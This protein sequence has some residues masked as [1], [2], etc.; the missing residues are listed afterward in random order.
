MRGYKDGKIFD[1]KIY[2][3]KEYNNFNKE[4]LSFDDQ[5]TV[6]KI[7]DGYIIT[8]M[9]KGAKHTK[10]STLIKTGT[11]KD[12]TEGRLY[13]GS[14]DGKK[15]RLF[16]SKT[17]H[18]IFVSLTYEES[19]GDYAEDTFGINKKDLLDE[20]FIDVSSDRVYGRYDPEEFLSHVQ[21]GFLSISNI[22][23]GVRRVKKF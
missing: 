6:T 21:K 9:R 2:D 12:N 23:Y 8:N 15:D 3:E 19:E 10:D 18:D 16:K 11:I 4:T 5:R 22:R 13:K 20:R 1:Q 17:L 14:D 7:K